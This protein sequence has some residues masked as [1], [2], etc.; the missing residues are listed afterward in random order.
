MEQVVEQAA[1][2][3]PRNKYYLGFSTVRLSPVYQHDL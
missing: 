1:L 3:L 2:L